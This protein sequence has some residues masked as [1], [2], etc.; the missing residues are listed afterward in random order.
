MA[1]P[2]WRPLVVAL[3]ISTGAAHATEAPVAL[4]QAATLGLS[5]GAA[6]ASFR[7]TPSLLG[8]ALTWSVSR[9]PLSLSVGLRFGFP[10][11]VPFEVVVRGLW[12]TALGPWRPRLGPELGAGGLEE[13]QHPAAL[14]PTSLA[15]TEQQA[16]SA[17][18]VGFRAE[19][20]RFVFGRVVV[21]ALA[22]DVGTTLSAPGTTLR[23]QLELLAG[24]WSW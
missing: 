9:G 7:T 20:A 22:F 12:G 21:S 14:R 23:Y 16:V 11:A 24:G 10:A 5:T 4:E 8:P 1:T 2:P 15:T 13:L 6:A 3:L 19:P 18:H 17:L